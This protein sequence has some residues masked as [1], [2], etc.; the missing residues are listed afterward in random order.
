MRLNL[1]RPLDAWFGDFAVQLIEVSAGGAS[2]L[3]DD[4]LPAGSRALLRFTWRG[5]DF[6]LLAEIARTMGPRSVVRLIDASE[7]LENLID[8]SADELERAREANASGDRARNV[9]GDAT[10]TAA[11]QAALLGRRFLV[12]EWTGG[13]WKCRVALVPDQPENGFTVRAGES[14]EQIE[15]LCRTFEAGDEASRLMT[16]KMAELSLGENRT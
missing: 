6:E 15:L 8:A 2:M 10:L 4:E 1:T 7:L 16:R 5:E 9:V 13:A 11:S 14:D 12:Y 3:H